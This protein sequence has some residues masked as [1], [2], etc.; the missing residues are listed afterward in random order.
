MLSIDGVK[1]KGTMHNQGDESIKYYQ[2][3]LKHPNVVAG[4]MDQRLR[5]LS[6]LT[7]EP[8]S[9][10]STAWHLSTSETTIQRI[11][12]SSG[13]LGDQLGIWC[14]GTYAGNILIHMK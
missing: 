8:G 7:K 2:N 12:L 14:T 4:A 5:A 9:I 13:F 6:A 3:L 1:T 11:L 10:P